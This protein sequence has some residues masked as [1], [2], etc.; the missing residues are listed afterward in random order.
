LTAFISALIFN[1]E[2]A[3]AK[4]VGVLKLARVQIPASPLETLQDQ[5]LQGFLVSEKEE[6]NTTEKTSLFVFVSLYS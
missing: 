6:E 4:G 1:S 5:R 2:S 3:P